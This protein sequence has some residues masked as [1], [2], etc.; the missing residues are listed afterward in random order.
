MGLL[1]DDNEWVRCLQVAFDF[2]MPRELR[3]LFVTICV[4]GNPSDIPALWR[5]ASNPH[6][7]EDFTRRGLAE[8]EAINRCLQE[9]ERLFRAVGQS[10]VNFGLPEPV[11]MVMPVANDGSAFTVAENRELGAEMRDTLNDR[12]RAIFDRVIDLVNDG[13]NQRRR[14]CLYLDGPGGSGKTH[15]MKVNYL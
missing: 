11:G 15:V 6:M 13:A 1:Q 14:R 7:I 2:Q 5:F 8:E 3:Q 4:E 10:C 9:V 12:Q